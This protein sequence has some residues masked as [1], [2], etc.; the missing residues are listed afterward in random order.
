[1]YTDK[2]L[3]DLGFYRKG[4]E[5][6]LIIGPYSHKLLWPDQVTGNSRRPRL[7]IRGRFLFFVPPRVWSQMSRFSFGS[8]DEKSHYFTTMWKECSRM[9]L[10]LRP[11][12]NLAK[13]NEKT[14]YRIDSYLTLTE[15]VTIV[16]AGQWI[17]KDFYGAQPQPAP[18]N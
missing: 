9:E 15:L 2:Q 3:S 4:A 8:D 10:P 7:I 1:M 11:H 12:Y 13:Y 17:E 14:G 5:R 18:A 6:H 16:K